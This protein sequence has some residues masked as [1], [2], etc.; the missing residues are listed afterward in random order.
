MYELFNIVTGAE[1]QAQAVL[2][3]AAMPWRDLPDSPEVAR[4]PGK[5]TRALEIDRKHTGLDLT[6]GS[7]L[8]LQSGRRVDPK[9]IRIGPRVGVSYAGAW[10]KKPLRFWIADHPAVS[11]GP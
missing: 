5:L 4:G 11:K 9:D 7:K 2:I 8:Y 1:G 3:R 6:S 10:A